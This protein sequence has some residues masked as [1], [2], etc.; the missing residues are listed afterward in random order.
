LRARP[1]AGPDDDRRHAPRARRAGRDRLHRG[2]TLTG[3]GA[4]CAAQAASLRERN[5][6]VRGRELRRS[7]VAAAPVGTARQ[8]AEPAS[9][10]RTPISIFMTSTK[11]ALYRASLLADNVGIRLCLAALLVM[12]SA[13]VFVLPACALLGAPS[14]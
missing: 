2:A 3:R 14:E 9:S 5:A 7:F 12:P 11:I 6:F 13:Y 4:R 1:P 10:G 8:R